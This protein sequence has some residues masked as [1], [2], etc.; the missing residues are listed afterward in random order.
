MLRRSIE[1][2]KYGG[3]PFAAIRGNVRKGAEKKEEKDKFQ[4][5]AGETQ[6]RN[7]R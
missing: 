1:P 2:S 6:G 3:Y 7:N 5:F 4:I